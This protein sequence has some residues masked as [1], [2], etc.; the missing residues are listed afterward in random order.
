ME[1]FNRINQILSLYD[2]VDECYDEFVE[3]R[4]GRR[5]LSLMNFN[6][7]EILSRRISPNIDL[8]NYTSVC[9]LIVIVVCFR[10]HDIVCSFLFSVFIG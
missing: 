10:H 6:M 3:Y 5:R 8:H 2:L 4:H 9:N 7:V 1:T